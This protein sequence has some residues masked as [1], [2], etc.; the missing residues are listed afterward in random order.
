MTTLAEKGLQ[1]SKN[2]LFSFLTQKAARL[3]GKPGKILLL[4]HDAYRKLT[5]ADNQKNGFAQIKDLMFTFI[6]LV[7]NF[8]NGRYRQV[9]RK[10][11]II[12]VATLLY[13]VLPIDLVPDFI[14]MFGL[15]DDLSLMAWFIKSFQGE[16]E[17]FSAWEATQ[18]LPA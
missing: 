12:G 6:R 4:L 9:S 8:T 11:I 18:A 16:L 13:L 1:I 5:T 2:T 17:K 14:P 7:R 15:M 3:L 10:S